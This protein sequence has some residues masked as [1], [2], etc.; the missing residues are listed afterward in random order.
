MIAEIERGH[1]KYLGTIGLQYLRGGDL[2][3]QD[4][5]AAEEWLSAY[6][7][8]GDPRTAQ[9]VAGLIM[10]RSFGRPDMAKALKYLTAASDGGVAEA[11]FDLGKLHLSGAA[12]DTNLPE[13]LVHLLRARDGDVPGANALIAQVYAG[14]FGNGH[15]AEG[16]EFHFQRAMAGKGARP[17]L[18]GQFGKMLARSA[19]SRADLLRAATTL[20]LAAAEGSMHATT[21]LGRVR[22]RLGQGAKGDFE[23]AARQGDATAALQLS[24][25]YSCGV[26]GHRSSKLAAV[27]REKAAVLGSKEALFR[28][29][30]SKMQA[31]L[32]GQAD[33]GRKLVKLAAFGESE[34]AIGYLV[35]RWDVGADGFDK[36]LIGVQR[37]MR[38]VTQ[39]PDLAFRDKA[40]AEVISARFKLAKT[41]GEKRR[42]VDALVGLANRGNQNALIALPALLKDG[43]MA[44]EAELLPLFKMAAA[45][46][47]PRAMREYGRLNVQLPYGDFAEGIR[48]LQAAAFAGDLKAQLFGIDEAAPDA[49]A[50]LD[51][52]AASGSVCHVHQMVDMARK[53]ADVSVGKSNS[54]SAHW[55]E[56]AQSS[57]TNDGDD[58][59]R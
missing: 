32:T 36:D 1:C 22:V 23:R 43:D 21:Q 20:E 37:L 56:L 3:V 10:A 48:Q 29:G 47:N 26:G 2:T 15:N 31:H 27:W 34:A 41:V 19:Q 9:K 45:L 16:A 5:F 54:K 53:Y 42:H 39:N 25:M 46:K 28:M 30:R 52:I 33:E 14:Q 11:S 58:L 40:L 6:A 49:I 55:L 57:V 35:S 51:K 24:K 50:Q 38:F 44:T 7:E 59:F 18:Q 17:Q 8:S 12:G 4:R 13:A